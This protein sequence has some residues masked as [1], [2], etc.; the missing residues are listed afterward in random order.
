MVKR[1]S[2]KTARRTAGRQLVQG[3]SGASIVKSILPVRGNCLY[4]V[5]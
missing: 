4:G 1:Q 2:L 3:A 5:P